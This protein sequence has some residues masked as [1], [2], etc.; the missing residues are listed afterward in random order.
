MFSISDTS[1]DSSDVSKIGLE[2]VAWRVEDA[3]VAFWSSPVL[4][5]LCK[6]TTLGL[7]TGRQGFF[8]IGDLGVSGSS[9]TKLL[10]NGQG[11]FSNSKTF[12]STP[13]NSS[14]LLL[15][16]DVSFGISIRQY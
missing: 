14:A 10:L 11:V 5:S 2:V 8:L 16:S 13:F 1:A 7:S 3:G 6:D 12:P 15:S 9:T 4:L